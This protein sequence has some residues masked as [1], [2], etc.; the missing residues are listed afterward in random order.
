MSEKMRPFLSVIMPIYNGERYLTQAIESVLNQECK[1]LELILV[2][3]GSKD[4]SEVICRLYESQD[5]RVTYYKKENTGVSDTRNFGIYQAKGRYIAFLD[6]DDIWDIKYYDAC[7]NKIL[8]EEDYD[9]LAFS[10]CFSDM[11]NNISEYIN[12]YSE[13][14]VDPKDKAVDKYYH[15]FCSFLFRKKFLKENALAFNTSL[16]YGEDELF[17]SQCLYLAHQIYAEDKISFY[18]RNNAYSST[19][20]NR[21]IKLFAKQKLDV[22]FQ[23]KEFFFE[24]YCKAGEEK[25]V[26]NAITARYFAE[27]IFYLCQIGYGWSAI[28]R[29]CESEDIH[30]IYNNSNQLFNL[31]HVQKNILKSYIEAPFAFYVKQRLHGMWYYP[32]VQVKHFFMKI[33]KGRRN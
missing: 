30:S 18:Y 19:K 29:L 28:K 23:L 33:K 27:A 6:C 24:Q 10:T 16:K 15:S 13:V 17:R 26:K 2:N 4:N 14:M 3:D 32:A 25:T 31:Y 21:N 5:E 8:Q 12:I 11:N 22:Y 7:L 20:V 1:D 9:V